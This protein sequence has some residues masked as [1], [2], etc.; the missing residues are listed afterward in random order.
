MRATS[1]HL[2]VLRHAKSDW[3][4]ELP[5]FD[6]DLDA[7]GRENIETLRL[8]L[9]SQQHLPQRIITSPARRAERTAE[10]AHAACI[11]AGAPATLEATAFRKDLRIY[12]ASAETMLRVLQE[13]A[14]DVTSLL[15]V[16]H[17][18]GIT[19]FVNRLGAQP[20]IETFPTCAI[21]RFSV[22]LPWHRLDFGEATLKLLRTPK[23]G[24]HCKDMQ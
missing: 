16:G 21:A 24:V 14:D 20:V 10:A 15:I 11:D 2:W 7:R 18:P 23:G 9:T 3:S 19:H 8:W 6:R 13:V 5:D 22:S 1:V 17:N 4:R 12:H